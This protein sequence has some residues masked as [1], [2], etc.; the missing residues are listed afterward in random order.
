MF[1]KM[2]KLLDRLMMRMMITCEKAAFLI[3]KS[4]DQKLTF[5]EDVQLRM[6][7]MGCRFCRAYERDLGL[8]S[9]SIRHY[10]EKPEKEPP[11]ELARSKKEKIKEHL[12]DHQQGDNDHPPHS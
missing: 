12:R 7:L 3:S 8:L 1:K 9:D 6:H 4:Q 5:S 11:M 10:R 2:K